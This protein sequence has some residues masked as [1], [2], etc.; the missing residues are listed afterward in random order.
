NSLQLQINRAPLE[1]STL[2]V[3][4]EAIFKIPTADPAAP[5]SYVAF[6]YDAKQSRAP[7]SFVT[8]VRVGLSATHPGAITIGIGYTTRG[9]GPTLDV[10]GGMFHGTPLTRTKPI[11]V[12]MH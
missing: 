3:S 7:N 10:I 2:P 11:A 9:A 12:R 8:E 4:V 5:P 6:G 1:S